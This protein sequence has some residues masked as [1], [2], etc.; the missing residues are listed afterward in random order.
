MS[1]DHTGVRAIR[2]SGLASRA[3]VDEITGLRD[4]I[5]DMAA[6]IARLEQTVLDMFTQLQCSSSAR[7]PRLQHYPLPSDAE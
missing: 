5:H 6:A 1:N 7:M 3:L 4:D 2:V